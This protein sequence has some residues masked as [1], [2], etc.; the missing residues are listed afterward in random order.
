MVV[1]RAEEAHFLREP[2]SREAALCYLSL[3]F[4][5]DAELAV[6]PGKPEGQKG[7]NFKRECPVSACAAVHPKR[8]RYLTFRSLIK[9]EA[10]AAVSPSRAA[11]QRALPAVHISGDPEVADNSGHTTSSF[12]LEL[13][14]VLRRGEIR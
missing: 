14:E 6:S 4:G 13:G 9:R 7:F 10:E 8:C 11:G 1:Q 5:F 12:R 3:A 2:P